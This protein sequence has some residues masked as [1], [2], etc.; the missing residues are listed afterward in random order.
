MAIGAQ[1]LGYAA[2]IRAASELLFYRPEAIFYS[3]GDTGFE[4]ES[5]SVSW[6]AA[7]ASDLRKHVGTG[8][9]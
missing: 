4:R 8:R 9:N 6:P 7:T 2:R 1:A 3:V 5:A